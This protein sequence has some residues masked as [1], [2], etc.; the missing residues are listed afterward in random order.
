MTSRPG[1]TALAAALLGTLPGCYVD[2]PERTYTPCDALGSA[3]WSARIVRGP[4][5]DRRD[6]TRP[7]LQVSGKV[8]VP[9]EGYAL[10]IDPGPVLALVPPVQQVILRT[11]PP[12][13]EA[14]PA[15]TTER[16][17]GTV[18]YRK[19]TQSVSVR[20]GDGTIALI[21]TIAPED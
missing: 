20:C 18:R 6:R 16:V 5:P 9:A 3:D 21:P 8:T 15:P 1:R 19:G 17:S 11:S 2:V 13:G 14:A 12:D 10:A 4:V 7:M